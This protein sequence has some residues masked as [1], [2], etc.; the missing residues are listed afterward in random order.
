MQDKGVFQTEY[1]VVF[2]RKAQTNL[3]EKI[4]KIRGD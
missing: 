2:P 1:F 4:L 3:G